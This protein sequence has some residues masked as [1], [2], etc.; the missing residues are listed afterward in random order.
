MSNFKTRVHLV[1]H[2]L[3]EFNFLSLNV[4]D[5]N[6]EIISVAAEASSRF[7]DDNG[8]ILPWLRCNERKTLRVPH[9]ARGQSVNVD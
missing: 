3:A 9:L 8:V 1:I 4:R 5:N 2:I 7:A 6:F